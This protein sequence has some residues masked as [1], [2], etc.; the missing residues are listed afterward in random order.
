MST[1][2]KVVL[3]GLGIVLTA[4]MVIPAAEPDPLI[5][6]DAARYDRGA[7]AYRTLARWAGERALHCE[8]QYWRCTP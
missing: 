5:P 8:A 6:R 1:Y 7:R 4:G 3:I 2:A